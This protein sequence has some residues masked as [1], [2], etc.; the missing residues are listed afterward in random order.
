MIIGIIG[1]LQSGKTTF[2]N[3]IKDLHP[4]TELLAFADSLKEV[5]YNAG[6]CSKEE[7]WEKKTEFSRLMMQRIGT[8]IIRKQVDSY[9]W[10]N[11]MITKLREI[12]QDKLIVIHD[13]R[14]QNEADMVNFLG[15]KL[16]RIIRPSLEQ[17]KEENNHLSETEQDSVEPDYLI[18]NDKSLYE[19]KKKA[20]D[21]L[22][23]YQ[24]GEF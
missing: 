2:A 21:I 15:G 18:V 6:I 1:K 10:V 5:I 13:I 3:I 7:L 14:F 19:L 22:S 12:D 11:K 17:N 9:F 8:E 23:R 20:E 4:E 24:A 16:I